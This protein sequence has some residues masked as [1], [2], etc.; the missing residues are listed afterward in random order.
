MRPRT[1]SSVAASAVVVVDLTTDTPAVQ[2]DDSLL[3]LWFNPRPRVRVEPPQSLE[4]DSQFTPNEDSQFT[5]NED[6]MLFT[7]G[8][9]G[10]WRR[11]DPPPPLPWYLEPSMVKD[12]RDLTEEGLRQ[13]WLKDTVMRRTLGWGFDAAADEIMSYVGNVMPSLRLCYI[14]ITC[15][16]SFR[17][18]QLGHV[19][20]FEGMDLLYVHPKAKHVFEGSTGL[21]ERGVVIRSST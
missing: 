5:P 6:P 20:E 9:D 3:D 1:R 17:W 16:P 10:A 8:T 11:V 15:Q 7:Q 18:Y 19:K 14:G 21:M 12:I 4:E 2:I 13:G